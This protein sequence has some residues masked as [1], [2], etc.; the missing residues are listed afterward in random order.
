MFDIFLFIIFAGIV[1][2]FLGFLGALVDDVN[3]DEKIRISLVFLFIGMVQISYYIWF[4]GVDHKFLLLHSTHLPFAISISPLLYIFLQIIIGANRDV[5]WKNILHFIPAIIVTILIIPYIYLPDA[6]KVLIISELNIGKT[7]LKYAILIDLI[8]YFIFFQILVYLV[9]FIIKTRSLVNFKSFRRVEVTFFLFIIILL[10]II[11][12]FLS[13]CGMYFFENRYYVFA[14]K[15]VSFSIT[16][17][18]LSLHLIHRKY[19]QTTLE[20]KKEFE[21]VKYENSNLKNVNLEKIKRKLDTL[22]EEQ[23]IYKEH[24]LSMDKLSNMLG[25]GVHKLSQYLN[26]ILKTNFY[27]FINRYRIIESEKLL[28]SDPNRTVLSIALEVGFS[29]QSTFYS[30]FKRKWKMSPN[31][32]RKK[33]GN[34]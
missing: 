3:A 20:V 17:L 14:H 4:L 8:R 22:L 28:L 9:H 11:T 19:P 25:I 5:N 26:E 6:E 23:K 16:L 2:S 33:F 30:A 12:L 31:V 15:C 34:L 7:T 18:L 29:S 13:I 32:Y 10:C 27:D 24:E 21:T 1:I